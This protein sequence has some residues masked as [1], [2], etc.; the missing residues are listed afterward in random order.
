MFTPLASSTCVVAEQR[1]G[2]ASALL[3]G[4][5]KMGDDALTVRARELAGEISAAEANLAAVL[6]EIE[7]REIH[8]QWECRNIERFAGWHLQQS[9]SRAR[10]LADVGRAMA[11]L[12]VLAEAVADGTLGFD[13]A[14]SIAR[15]AAPDTESALVELALHATTAQTQRICGKWRKTEARDSPDPDGQPADGHPTVM[16]IKGDDGITL[17]IRFDH[18]RGE[19]VLASIE[20][21]ARAVRAERAD[22]AALDPA[23]VNDPDGVPA[24]DEDR[25]V[26]KLTQAEWRALGLLRLAERSAAEQPEGLQ[27]SGFDTTVVVHVGI[28]TLYGPDL[29][30]AAD[31]SA[32]P[33]R[34]EMCELEPSG[35]R[36]RRD[37]ARWLACDAGLLTVIEDRDGNPL[38]IGRRHSIIPVALRR[39]VMA[40]YRTCAWPGCVATAVQLHHVQHRSDHGHDDVENLVPE[41]LEH[42]VVIHLE[43]IWITRDPDGTLHHWRRDGAEI[44][45]NP[46]AGHTPVSDALAAPAKLTN[47]RLDLGADPDE[48]SRQPRWHGDPLHLGDCIEAI[49]ARR[50]AALRRTN[51]TRD[52]P[53]IRYD[54]GPPP[55]L[56]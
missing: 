50:D 44:V 17:T 30:D 53:A 33:E 19:L 21:E 51:P 56:N 26:E 22:A 12:P 55:N 3:E 6:A 18:V 45:A 48:T 5:S 46:A 23:N 49:E 47:R 25:A 54:T 29:P 27:R 34:D 31:R 36:L 8:S 24:C 13:K 39:A 52:A 15:V 37:I 20:A 32:R 11:E 41:C 9:P 2:V 38:H 35:V 14:R 1:G 40:R 42:H 28:D 10:G 7:R 16:V 4:V 43:G